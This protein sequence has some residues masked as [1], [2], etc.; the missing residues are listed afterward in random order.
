MKPF[1]VK[2]VQDGFIHKKTYI[3]KKTQFVHGEFYAYFNEHSQAVENQLTYTKY[4]AEARRMIIYA[5]VLWKYLREL[6][7][8]T[9]SY[10]QIIQGAMNILPDTGF[11]R[12]VLMIEYLPVTVWRKLLWRENIDFMSYESFLRRVSKDQAQAITD[13]YMDVEKGVMPR[14]MKKSLRDRIKIFFGIIT[15]VKLMAEPVDR[16]LRNTSKGSWAFNLLGIDFG[17]GLYP[18]GVDDDYK[19][20]NKKF[21]RFISLK[22]H[23]NDFVVNQEDGK[24]WW[25]YKTARSN[26]AFRPQRVVRLKNHICPGFW[27]TLFV[28]LDF[29]ILSP[30]GCMFIYFFTPD[31]HENIARTITLFAISGL[32]PLWFCFLIFRGIFFMLKIIIRHDKT[33]KLIRTVAL[34][35]FYVVCGI[36]AM[37]ACFIWL[38]SVGLKLGLGIVSSVLLPTVILA[39]LVSL[40]KGDGDRLYNLAPKWVKFLAAA[41]TVAISIQIIVMHIAMPAWKMISAASS[42]VWN[43][44]LDY[45]AGATLFLISLVVFERMVRLYSVS[46]KDEEKFAK[47][48]RVI[49][50]MLV[51]WIAACAITTGVEIMRS[52]NFILTN[53]S[54][55]TVFIVIGIIPI[56]ILIYFRYM[57]VNP[58]TINYRLASSKLA[59]LANKS[60][61]YQRYSFDKIDFWQ[62]DWLMHMPI[63]SAE[64]TLSKAID[65]IKE[66]FSSGLFDRDFV[67]QM[68]LPKLTRNI[69]KEIKKHHQD[70]R[71]VGDNNDR[72]EVLLLILQGHTGEDA[73]SIFK[74]A[75]AKHREKLLRKERAKEK[76]QEFFYRF[77]TP[78][79][80]TS[81]KISQFFGTLKDLWSLF[82]ER[83][84]YVNHPRELE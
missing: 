30:I 63:T 53:V 22:N 34:I 20:T 51:I 57:R 2:F 26:I 72:Y 67:M 77:F 41:I 73:L 40:C 79:R 49:K 55:P 10:R 43:F 70:I 80:Y 83:C 69:L 82:N 61:R 7:V 50:M 32:M 81:E 25:M 9:E 64:K 65:F 45:P 71:R 84:P 47:Q 16:S 24:Y 66:M 8:S 59:A 78:F 44:F 14:V 36:V 17:F 11:T 5:L 38:Y 58:R 76:R 27:W 29:W 13:N 48:S 35:V 15:L 19:I 62:N 1:C 21:T 23:I 3:M 42:R 37:T 60:I 31:W 6:S 68:V 54:L 52:G 46:F 74:G 12:L 56:F 4:T 28:H 18:N 75:K 33:L 39:Y